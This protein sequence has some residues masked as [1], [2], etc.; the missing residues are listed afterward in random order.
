MKFVNDRIILKRETGGLE[1]RLQ[2]N[3]GG[4]GKLARLRNWIAARMAAKPDLTLDDLVLDIAD[5]HQMTVHRVSVWRT[6]H[7]LGLTPKKD[8][9]AVGRKRPEVRQARHVSITRRQPFIANLLP[10]IGFIDGTSLRTNMAKMTGWSPK[11]TRLTCHTPFGH[12][13]ARTFIAALRHDRL[14][15]PWVINGAMN[16]DPFELYVET[17]LAPTL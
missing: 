15:A 16:R 14:D 7:N 3:G 8:L 11:G 6:L 4:H 2:G 9:Q 17:Q 13:N 5:A 12:R 10:R 1:P